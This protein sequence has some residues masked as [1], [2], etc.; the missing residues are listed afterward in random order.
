MNEAPIRRSL[1][2]LPGRFFVEPQFASATLRL[3][4]TV[5]DALIEAAEVARPAWTQLAEA[6][7]SEIKRFS[8][9]EVQMS[10]SLFRHPLVHG[11]AGAWI[12]ALKW[13]VVAVYGDGAQ[14]Q[15]PENLVVSLRAASAVEKMEFSWR[16]WAKSAAAGSARTITTATTGSTLTCPFGFRWQSSR[17]SV[18]HSRGKFAWCS[19][20][21]WGISD[22]VADRS[23]QNISHTLAEWRR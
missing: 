11:F 13:P 14:L 15:L 23:A 20:T 16:R 21:R 1:T 17:N 5:A 4:D 3:A 18:I 8:E 2:S 19:I 9:R 6:F 12:T 7:D 10:G 22:G